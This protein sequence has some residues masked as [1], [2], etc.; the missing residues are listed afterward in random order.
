MNQLTEQR[1]PTTQATLKR[2]RMR[3]RWLL[4]VLSLAT[5]T[6]ILSAA[7][8]RAPLRRWLPRD[9]YDRFQGTWR[10]LIDDR[11]TPH[12]LCIEN[13]RWQYLHDEGT[14]TYRLELDMT[15]SPRQLRLELLDTR[16]LIG[17]VPRL[18]GLYAFESRNQ[19]RLCLLPATEP[20]PP[21]W[22]QAELTLTLLRE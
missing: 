3:R 17:P 18:H 7:G 5:L 11:E 22:D 6:G 16:G 21:D 12:R 8:V 1:R 19:V 15:A 2:W 13:H 9:D 14:R 20:L 4:L 10:I